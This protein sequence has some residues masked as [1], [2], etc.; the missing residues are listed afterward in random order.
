MS[1]YHS[2]KD[3]GKCIGPT[4]HLWHGKFGLQRLTISWN[5]T[6][7]ACELAFFLWWFRIYLYAGAWPWKIT[8]QSINWQK[9]YRESVKF[10]EETDGFGF[11]NHGRRKWLEGQ[12]SEIESKLS[13][14]FT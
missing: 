2:A 14:M 11:D 6:R 3:E 10:Y 13:K 9:S 12:K 4:I 7:S 1:F 8:F 5:I